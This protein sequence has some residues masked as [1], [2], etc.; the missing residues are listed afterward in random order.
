M[1][2]RLTGSTVFPW[3]TRLVSDACVS[4]WVCI[5]IY[6]YM[7]LSWLDM[8][9]SLWVFA[10]LAK[11]NRFWWQRSYLWS[12]WSFWRQKL[13]HSMLTDDF[14]I[15]LLINQVCEAFQKSRSSSLIKRWLHTIFA[16]CHVHISL[17]SI[18]NYFKWW[19]FFFCMC[20]FNSKEIHRHTPQT[21][22]M[23]SYFVLAQSDWL[24]YYT[25]PQLL[26]YSGSKKYLQHI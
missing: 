19:F 13:E 20:C 1:Q 15:S 14:R 16:I 24:D 18:I 21:K 4:Q 23:A 5:Y 7:L 25:T 12:S 3:F 22:V 9:Y 8:P 17:Q 6:I 11:T 26:T 10:W 2:Q